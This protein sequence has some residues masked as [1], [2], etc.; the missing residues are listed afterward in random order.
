MHAR[1]PIRPHMAIK[2]KIEVSAGGKAFNRLSII[3]NRELY[4]TRLTTNEALLCTCRKRTFHASTSRKCPHTLP[5]TIETVP[6]R[7]AAAWTASYLRLWCDVSAHWNRPH[8]S[9]RTFPWYHHVW[10]NVTRLKRDAA[11]I[12]IGPTSP[13]QDFPVVPPRMAKRDK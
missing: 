5:F 11:P 1:R 10:Q 7:Q 3:S 4:G 13:S 8:S 9:S 2:P 6:M 12:G